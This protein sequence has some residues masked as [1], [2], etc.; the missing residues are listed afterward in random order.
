M[1]P[2][3]SPDGT[4]ITYSSRRTGTRDIWV[5][6]LAT[7]KETV[8]STRPASAFGSVFSADG[9][10]V[11]Y[12]SVEGQKSIVYVV[13]LADGSQQRVPEGCLSTVGW[14]S[15]G[16]QF[17]CALAAPSRIST[18]DVGSKKATEL[19]THAT[20]RLWNPRVSPDDRWVTFNA[21]TAGRS[22]IFVAPF[23]K[24]GLIPES[25]WITITSGVWDDKPRWS[26][27]GNTLYFLSE[28]DRFRCIWAQR[29]DRSKRPLGEAI[30]MFHAHESRRSL[31]NMQIGALD[32]SVARDKT[33]NIWMMNLS[34]RR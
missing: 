32:L 34:Q 21:T 1:Y 31:L 29:L 30:P 7:G 2:A 20:W 5:K 11:A 8:V 3:V 25:E 23:R 14:M 18:I 33:G 26:P 15:D 27:D 22:R 9:G 19:V 17:L 12:R 13:S 6:D 4:K 28:R 10:L 16:K 24:R